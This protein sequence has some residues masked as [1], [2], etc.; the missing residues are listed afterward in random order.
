MADNLFADRLRSGERLIGTLVSVPSP[1]LVE[2]LS[3]TGLDWL[4]IDMEHGGFDRSDVVR[5]LQ[6]IRQPCAGI[7]RVPAAE[8]AWLKGALDSG[9][10]GIIVPHVNSAGAA[11]EIVAHCKYPPLGSRSVGIARAHGYGQR[12]SEAM[13]TANSSVA[14]IAQVEHIDAVRHID[15]LVAVEGLDAL[16]VGPY[17]LSASMGMVGQP[18]HPDVLTAIQRVTDTCRERKPLGIFGATPEAVKPFVGAGYT[19]LA[20]GAIV[21]ELRSDR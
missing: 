10:D 21:A 2:A 18:S 12:F 17:D 14:L 11:R 4:F 3:L 16:F 20:A 15:D 19:L 5:A 6:A 8:E 9:A 13:Q 1:E 7:V